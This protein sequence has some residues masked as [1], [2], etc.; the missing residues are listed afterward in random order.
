VGGRARDHRRHLPLC[1]E[2]VLDVRRHRRGRHTTID[3]LA[4]FANW[5]DADNRI[6]ESRSP[7]V[8]PDFPGSQFFDLSVNP[9]VNEFSGQATTNAFSYYSLEITE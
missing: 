5:V 8:L 2:R 4:D 3:N 1:G 9:P 7:A 6:A